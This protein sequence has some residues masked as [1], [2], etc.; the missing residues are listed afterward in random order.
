MLALFAF[1]FGIRLFKAVL[2]GTR[3]VTQ[4]IPSDCLLPD[5]TADPA[6]LRQHAAAPDYIHSTC[7]HSS[8]AP[9]PSRLFQTIGTIEL[10]SWALASCW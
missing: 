1:I 7:W 6:V 2:P 8:S 10:I 4:R 9:M 3:T 5:G